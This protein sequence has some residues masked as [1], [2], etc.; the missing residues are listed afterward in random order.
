MMPNSH[1]PQKKEMIFPPDSVEAV[2]ATLSKRR[3]LT[4]SDVGM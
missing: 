1:F 4:K 2:S 3:R